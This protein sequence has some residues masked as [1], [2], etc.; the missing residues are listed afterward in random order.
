[1]N[2]F[3]QTFWDIE[4]NKWVQS[5][6]PTD[7]EKRMIRGVE[8]LPRSKQKELNIE[9]A[10]EKQKLA[11]QKKANNISR[12]VEDFETSKK[13][14]NM[15]GYQNQQ[16]RDRAESRKIEGAEKVR[17]QQ[18]DANRRRAEKVEKAKKAEAT[19]RSNG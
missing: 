16:N 5:E 9:R 11:A 10:V 4:S 18:D 14:K 17:I 3:I 6:L 8:D 7:A 13:A 15:R 19:A 1:M 2:Q 12:M